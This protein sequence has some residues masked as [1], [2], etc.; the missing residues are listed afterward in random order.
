MWKIERIYGDV[1]EKTRL[2][3]AYHHALY[4]DVYNSK[5]SNQNIAFSNGSQ[6]EE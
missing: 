4:P 6:L 1:H 2:K 5:K 3:K